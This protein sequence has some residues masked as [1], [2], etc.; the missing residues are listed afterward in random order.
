[1]NNSE[2]TPQEIQRRVCST[3]KKSF[4]FKHQYKP[5][6]IRYFTIELGKKYKVNSTVKKIN[7]TVLETLSFI[8]NMTDN[9]DF[10][11]PLGVEVRFM[12]NNQTGTYYDLHDLEETTED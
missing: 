3:G 11:T 1:M 10:A 5:G 4:Q 9:Q 12:K 7:G 6:L 2:N 8:Y